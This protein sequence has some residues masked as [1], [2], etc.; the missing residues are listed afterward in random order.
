MSSPRVTALINT[1]NYGRFVEEAIESVLA[2]DS[3]ASEM[4]ILLVDDG[5]TDDTRERVA[6]FGDHVRYL[7]KPNGGQ[8][9]AV[10]L[11]YIHARGEIIALLDADDVWLPQKIRRAVETFDRQ[12]ACGMLLHKRWVWNTTQQ[13]SLEDPDLPV[14]SGEFPPTRMDLLRYGTSS[15][16]GLLFRKSIAGAVFPIPDSMSLLV[17]AYLQVLLLFLAPV[18][19][20][21]EP[22]FKYRLHTNNRFH[23]GEGDAERVERRLR[24]T[25]AL[26]QETRAWL[27]A[28]GFDTRAPDLAAFMSRFDLIEQ[29]NRFHA[30]RAGRLEFFRHLQLHSL[31]YGPLWTRRYRAYRCLMTYVGLLL[32]YGAFEKLRNRHALGGASLHL[33]RHFL[34]AETVESLSP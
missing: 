11:G 16:S 4:E 15:T 24:A 31:V 14:L 30:T 20:L 3:P 19:I 18:A 5:S 26:T 32:G 1:Y 13:T 8:A 27:D 29:Q 23:F 7:W 2:Q 33:R 17:D 25:S 9:S 21:N 28:H 22:L 10:N 6:K 12:P 34:P